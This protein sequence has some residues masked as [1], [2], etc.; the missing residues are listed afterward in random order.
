MVDRPFKLLIAG[1]RKASTEMLDLAMHAVRR[2]AFRGWAI[3]VGDAEGVDLA[4]IEAA[5]R[6]NVP[7]VIYGITA[8]PRNGH[9]EYVRIEG[10]FLARDRY[11]A[12]NAD[13]GFFVWNGH[14]KGTIYTFNYMRKLKKPCDLRTFDGKAKS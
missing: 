10:D 11:M 14:S 13:R 1:S 6:E 9:G 5:Q 12:Q 8:R 4:V 7:Y 2:A 3:V